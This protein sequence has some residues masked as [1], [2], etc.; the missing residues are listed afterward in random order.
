MKPLQELYRYAEQENIAVDRFALI[1]REALSI[2]DEDGSCFVAIDP[3]KIA[4]E[5]DERTKLSH[6]LGHCVT[7]SFYNQYSDFDCRQRH[8]NKADKWAIK[9]LIPVDDLDDAIT[10]GCTEIW[11]LAER[12]GVTEQFMQKAVCYYVHGN[13]AS[14]LYF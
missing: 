2:M 3:N 12:F 14:E 8:E 7:G 10:D 1:K 13:L 6:E 4:N 9:H 5:A 11:E